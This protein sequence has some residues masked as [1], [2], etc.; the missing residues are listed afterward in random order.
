MYGSPVQPQKPACVQPD[1]DVLVDL[2]GDAGLLE[3]LRVGRPVVAGFGVGDD[4]AAAVAV[5]ADPAG[6]H[7]VA[8]RV[9]RPHQ[10]AVVGVAD[11]EGIGQRELERHVAARVV[12]HRRRRPCSAPTGRSGRRSRRRACRSSRAAG[13]AGTSAPR[14]VARPA[15][16]AAARPA[17]SGWCQTGLP[18]GSVTARGSPNPRTPRSVPK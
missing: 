13:P 9:G 14:S 8:V 11:R 18:D 2:P 17:P 15:G 12:G 3:A 5:V 10:R 16:T 7:V 1:A 4:R 6:P